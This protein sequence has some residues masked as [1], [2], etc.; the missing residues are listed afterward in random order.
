LPIL[1]EYVDEVV[2]LGV[3]G[4]ILADISLL[5]ALRKR[6]PELELHASTLAHLGNS[7]AVR[8]YIE[9][10]INRMVFPRHIPVAEFRQI[11]EACPEISYDAFLLVG[12]CPNTE[13]LCTFHHSSPDKVWPCEIPYDIKALNPER[14]ESLKGVIRRQASWSETNRRHGCGLCAIPQLLQSGVSGLKLVGRGAP[15]AQKVKNILLAK[16][17]LHLATEIEDFDDY[18]SQA[19]TAHRNR[20]GADCSPNICYFPEFYMAE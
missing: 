9:S 10:G 4:I 11:V 3:D 16:D 14:N 8:T 12:K 2:A 13:G 20:F 18:R 6:H 7:R 19:M 5:R 15:M 17:F 1:L